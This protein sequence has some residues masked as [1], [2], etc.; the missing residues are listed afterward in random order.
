M[1]G[2][3]PPGA[4]WNDHYGWVGPKM[5]ADGQIER[6]GHRASLRKLLNDGPLTHC[7]CS[8]EMRQNYIDLAMME[9]P[10]CDVNGDEIFITEAGR[11]ALRG[12]M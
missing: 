9:P 3:P 5:T 4:V 1:S 8:E 10:L 2:D 7:E 6:G 12:G 11:L